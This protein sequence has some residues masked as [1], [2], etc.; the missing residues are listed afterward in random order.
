MAGTG[1]LTITPFSATL[2]RDTDFF[3][4]MDPY[5]VVKLGA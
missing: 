1:N 4:R 3:D 5:V 2:I